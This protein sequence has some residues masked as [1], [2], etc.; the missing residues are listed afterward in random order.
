MFGPLWI[1]DEQSACVASVRSILRVGLPTYLGSL[2]PPRRGS[3]TRPASRRWRGL[4]RG[5]GGSLRGC[6]CGCGCG[7]RY[8]SRDCSLR[9]PSVP[10]PPAG[11]SSATA[12]RLASLPVTASATSSAIARATG[13]FVASLVIVG[14]NSASFVT[15]PCF[16]FLALPSSSS[17]TSELGIFHELVSLV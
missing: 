16:P 4:G 5:R 2:G 11:R 14:R 7:C 1:D 10:P 13:L 17:S 8:S 6:G 12:A 15:Q 9:C 3:C